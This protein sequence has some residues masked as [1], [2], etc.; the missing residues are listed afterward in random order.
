MSDVV[1]RQSESFYIGAYRVNQLLGEGA[2]GMVYQAYQPFL[3][4]DVAIKTLHTDLASDKRLE[5]QFMHEARTIARLRHPNIVAAYEFGTTTLRNQQITF[6]VM[7]YL[8]GKTLQDVLKG[9]GLPVPD[10]LRILGQIAAALDYAHS[11]NVIHRDLKPANI[12][13]SEQ[14]QPVIVDFGLAKLMTLG[15]LTTGE[16]LESTMSGT[17]AYMAPEQIAN[18]QVGPAVDQYALATVAY[19]MLTQRLPFNASTTSQLMNER[20]TGEPQ[21]IT[22]MNPA[23]PAALDVVFMQALSRNPEDRYPSASAFVEDVARILLPDRFPAQITQVIDPAQAA[24]LRVAR[25]TI[26]GFLWS[27]VFATLLIIVFATAQFLHGYTRADAPFMWDGILAS[28]AVHDGLHDVIAVWPGSPAQKAGVL[29][30]DEIKYD[31][32][33]DRTDQSGDYQIN[34]RPRS[35]YPINWIPQVG[36]EITRTVVRGA[37][38]LSVHYTMDRSIYLLIVLAVQL[39]TAFFAFVA[40]VTLIRRW[41]AEPGVQFLAVIFLG[42]SFAMVT[43]GIANVFVNIDTLAGFIML[44]LM[45]HFVLVFPRPDPLLPKL[46]VVLW[47][48]YAPTLLGAIEF[49]LGVDWIDTLNLN[50]IFYTVL[51]VALLL[52]VLLKWA[53]RDLRFFPRLK[54]MIGMFGCIAVAVLLSALFFAFDDY[55]TVQTFWAGNGFN[56]YAAGYAV[57]IIGATVGIVF[58]LYGYHQIQ[59]AMGPSLLESSTSI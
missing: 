43:A 45:I 39:P 35:A 1:I 7:E 36:D 2:F 57:L 15:G 29:P 10:A 48:L 23:L 6:M 54:Y 44:P 47:L 26:L 27:A 53:R 18:T 25:R 22:L 16:L 32:T 41:G 55:H 3:D 37:N 59:L 42:G 9:D 21:P 30:G 58:G 14:N 4:R 52:A 24:E 49:M 13:F 11:H 8:P 19:Q 46:R 5:Q 20:M 56:L 34:G 38:Q 33:Y 51:T 40:A 17:P 31:L 50:L 12:M 28:I